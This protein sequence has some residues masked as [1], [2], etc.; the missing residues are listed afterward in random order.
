ML[1][2]RLLRCRHDRGCAS[3]CVSGAHA[4]LRLFVQE[5]GS[6]IKALKSRLESLTNPAFARKADQER[7]DDS[8]TRQCFSL[9]LAAAE[10][11]LTL[12]DAP[13]HVLALTGAHTRERRR[14]SVT[15]RLCAG[16]QCLRVRR[17]S[18]RGSGNDVM[19]RAVVLQK[20]TTTATTVRREGRAPWHAQVGTTAVAACDCGS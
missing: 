20:L 4:Q 11:L 15:V 17:C 6:E 10:R 2:L 12:A 7:W 19:P 8:R 14:S 9:L 5:H 1:L 3:R 16:V 13:T 18:G